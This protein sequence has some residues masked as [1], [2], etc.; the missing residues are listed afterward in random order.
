[1]RAKRSSRNGTALVRVDQFTTTTSPDSYRPEVCVAWPGIRTQEDALGTGIRALQASVDHSHG[2]RYY[3]AVM[4]G[5][6][7]KPADTAR[8]TTRW[9]DSNRVSAQAAFGVVSLSYRLTRLFRELRTTSGWTIAGIVFLVVGLALRN[10]ILFAAFAAT[11]ALQ[12]VQWVYFRHFAHRARIEEVDEMTGWEFERWLEGF[13]KQLGFGV[14][15]TPYRGD[16]GADFVLS[17]N[18]A[19]IA[20]QAKRTS[21]RVGVRAIQEVVAAK[22]YYECSHSMVV[23]NS[24]FTDQAVILAR[25]NDVWMRSR[26]DLARSAA[27]LHTIKESVR[28][29]GHPLDGPPP[30]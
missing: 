25:A 19:R 26:D 2:R 30:A 8:V 23:T 13:F 12:T 22:A 14:E 24:Y 21:V 17:W 10:W 3:V 5:L 11:L 15:R 1:M 6:R 9:K 7:C 27:G 28:Q 16:F 20:V 29:S 4:V 18:N